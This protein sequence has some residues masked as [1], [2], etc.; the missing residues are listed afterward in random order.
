M[1]LDIIYN[2][3]STAIENC[4]DIDEVNKVLGDETT[5][6]RLNKALKDYISDYTLS[7]LEHI[8]FNN[9]QEREIILY[10]IYKYKDLYHKSINT[11]S[12]L[13]EQFLDDINYGNLT[14]IT[15]RSNIN[16]A[17]SNLKK[18]MNI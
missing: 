17:K 1:I 10:L 11:L 2:A 6:E 3:V 7:D 15:I 4:K 8:S 12:D 14:S 16:D 9:I 18:E 13:E 5:L